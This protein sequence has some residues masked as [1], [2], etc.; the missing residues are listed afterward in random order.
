MDSQTYSNHRRLH[1]IYH[2][3]LTLVLLATLTGIV[4]LVIREG[5]SLSAVLFLLIFVIIAVSFFL[6]RAY[7][8]KAQDRA[9]R[10]E[11]NLRHYVLTGQLLDSRLTISQITAL[12]FASDA[13]FPELCRKAAA[14]N[15]SPN[16]IKKS[17]NTWRADNYRI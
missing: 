15:L 2:F 3:F 17:I 11:E 12:R 9:I 6:V 16:A 14:Q 13:E 5:L 10:A 4:V 8:L 7:P 1:P